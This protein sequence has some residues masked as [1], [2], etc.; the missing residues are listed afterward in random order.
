VSEALCRAVPPQLFHGVSWMSGVNEGALPSAKRDRS[1]FH[2]SAPE[3][4]GGRAGLLSGMRASVMLVPQVHR[5][6][7]A[8][9]AHIARVRV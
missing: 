5:T 8:H 6:A 2:R 3:G 7:V 9:D 4:A 1:E